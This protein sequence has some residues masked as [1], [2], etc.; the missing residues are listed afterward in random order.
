M[1][2]H[3]QLSDMQEYFPQFPAPMQATLLDRSWEQQAIAPAHIGSGGITRLRIRPGMEIAS[4]EGSVVFLADEKVYLERKAGIR[5]SPE[6]FLS[7]SEQ[8]EDGSTSG[9]QPLLS[10]TAMPAISRQLFA[11]NTA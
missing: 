3:I 1:K 7:Y 11:S 5:M 6:H 8:S 10:G 9:R 2:F 4:K